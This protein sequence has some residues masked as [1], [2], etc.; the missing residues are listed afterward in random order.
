MAY[1]IRFSY[2]HEYVTMTMMMKKIR[3]NSFP[4]SSCSSVWLVLS[5][6]TLLVQ[7]SCLHKAI[8]D[9]WTFAI[10]PYDSSKTRRIMLQHEHQPGEKK[11]IPVLLTNGHQRNHFQS[12]SNNNFKKNYAVLMTA[13]NEHDRTQPQ[14]QQQNDSPQQRQP[15]EYS[16]LPDNTVQPSRA[17]PTTNDDE[18]NDYN[19]NNNNDSITL[20][21]ESIPRNANDEFIQNY[22]FSE[23]G[24]QHHNNNN[25]AIINRE[26]AE[27]IYNWEQEHRQQ[28]Q[29]PQLVQFSVRAGIR[30]VD[31]LAREALHLQQQQ[32]PQPQQSDDG[33]GGARI[34]SSATLPSKSSSMSSL[35]SENLLTDPRRSSVYSDLIQEGLEALLEAMSHY[36]KEDSTGFQAYATQRIRQAMAQTLEQTS[37]PVTLPPHIRAVVAEA[38]QVIQTLQQQGKEPTLKRIAKRMK[39]HPVSPARLQECLRLAARARHD[40]SLERTVQ[41]SHPMLDDSPPTIRDREE[42]ELDQ[43]LLLDNGQSV[44]RDELV[45]D[46][47]DEMMDREG[48]DDSWIQE[49]EQVAGSLQDIIPDLEPTLV[50]D[51]DDSTRTTL[52]TQDSDALSDMIRNDL[53]NFL[54][55][56]LEPSEVELVRLA[57]GLDTGRPISMKRVAHHMDLTVPAVTAQLTRAI[58]KLQQAYTSRYIEPYQDDDQTMDSV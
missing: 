8:C 38:R 36:P 40:V 54:T 2:A 22:I 24:K 34:S 44:R 15:P 58:R 39:D 29:L 7:L 32:Q 53:S 49:Q 1:G 47:L 27:R 50:E 48:D 12:R 26:L 18:N 43:G 35:S 57:F 17:H 3:S 55:T 52:T 37:R 14:E 45:E 13:S 28:E 4:P 51:E 41:V 46:Y 33:G 42:W 5:S 19:S 16:S 10:E 6:L 25:N 30:L 56:T 23:N 20:A 21:A 11:A 9:A 31:E